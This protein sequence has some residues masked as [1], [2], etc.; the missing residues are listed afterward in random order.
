ME[1]IGF[2]DEE[3]QIFVWAVRYDWM[4]QSQA[5]VC[6]KLTRTHIFGG[7]LSF[8]FVLAKAFIWHETDQH[9]CH[10]RLL[11]ASRLG[12][13]DWKNEGVI[14]DYACEVCSR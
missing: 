9:R 10:S 12:G 3:H 2:S 4:V 1:T 11:R 6:V 8:S 5:F 14:N 7:L 13:Y